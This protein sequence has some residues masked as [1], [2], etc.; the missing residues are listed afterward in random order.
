MRNLPMR[1]L[2]NTRYESDEF[3]YG[4]AP[5]QFFKDTL[6]RFNLTGEI[7][8]PA[9]GEGRN[10]VYAA[11]KGLS[12]YAFDISVQ[13]RIKALKLAKEKNVQIR[14]EVGE[15]T[16]LVL[17]DESFDN[18]ALIFAHLPPNL[19][20][21]FHREIAELIKPGGIIILEGFSKNNLKIRQEN[22]NI[23]GPNNLE[24][25]FSEAEIKEDFRNFEIVELQEV[26]VELR[27]GNTHNGF[28]NVIRFIGRKAVD[29]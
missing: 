5:N 19:R 14:Y 28:G 11:Q 8:L 1:D 24:M 3:A 20:P 26:N 25:L 6:N 13:G 27:E 22:P 10:A 18:A 17:E 7:L 29:N 21:S 9:E 2:W 12:V 15:I 23:G 4:K 16:D